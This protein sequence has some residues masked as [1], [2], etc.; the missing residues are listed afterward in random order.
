MTRNARTRRVHGLSR[1]VHPWHLPEVRLLVGIGLGADTGAFDLD[2]LNV[3]GETHL[4]SEKQLVVVAALVG[5]SSET[6]ETVEV[7]LALEGGNLG[8]DERRE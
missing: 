2:A 5:T 6:I 8:Q 4:S 7:Q 3:L 1:G